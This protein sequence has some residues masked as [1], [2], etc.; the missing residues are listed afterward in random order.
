MTADDLTGAADLAATLVAADVSACVL[1]HRSR[2]ENATVPADGTGALIQD[3]DCRDDRPATVCRKI[4]RSVRILSP[5][6]MPHWYH[7]IDS[8]LR[9]TIGDQILALMGALD[10]RVAVM[11]PANPVQGRVTRHG[12]QYVHGVALARSAFRLDPVWPR[13]ASRV[14]RIVGNL[15]GVR[16]RALRIEHVAC[17][18]S[19]L[20]EILEH[21]SDKRT[22][23]IVDALT[24]RHLRTIAHAVRT[25]PLVIGSA[26]LA[27]PLAS[28]WM[29]AD[30][31]QR[32]RSTAFS[33]WASIRPGTLIV[34]GS[35]APATLRQN[36]AVENQLDEDM[37][38]LVP[39][40][41]RSGHRRQSA[42]SLR[43][44]LRR[45]LREHLDGVGRI[46]VSGGQT[47]ADV[48]AG[49]GVRELR[50]IRLIAPGIGIALA[51][52]ERDLLMVLKPGSFG[53]PDFYRRAYRAM[54]GLIED[55]V[56]R[57][58]GPARA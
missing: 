18:A 50:I 20:S 19:R 7:K 28:L 44:A 47:A 35:A 39:P 52:G 53:P 30:S 33:S 51:R 23:A 21:F 37:R 4:R 57:V 41:E 16:V 24:N 26:A 54:D 46:I 34:A 27:G 58:R 48:C 49:L 8:G 40:R 56:L 29:T 55:G 11:A 38:L 45:E 25:F 12:V 13:R 2:T 42:A 32:K 14:A 17:G 9:G 6:A 31:R 5:Q 22:L 43:V 10:V 1:P 36:Q 3:L 15:P